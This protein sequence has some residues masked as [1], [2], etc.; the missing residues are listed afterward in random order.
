MWSIVPWISRWPTTPTT[1]WSF[2]GAR[3]RA[4]KRPRHASVMRH[5]RSAQRCRNT[6]P[7]SARGTGRRTADG[8]SLLIQHLVV[9]SFDVAVWRIAPFRCDAEFG[10]L[11]SIAD[12]DR[13]APVE[14]D[15]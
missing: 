5:R 7:G 9:P 3:L 15:L 4:A 2:G 10:R 14:L 1:A 11:R 12:I 8:P 13:A 6:A